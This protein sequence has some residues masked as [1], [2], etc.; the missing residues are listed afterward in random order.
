MVCHRS[1]CICVHRASSED[2]NSKMQKEVQNGL[3]C[4]VFF[5]SLHVR[6]GHLITYIHKDRKNS[7]I[8]PF[9]ASGRDLHE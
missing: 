4:M 1:L 5:R 6:A 2:V 7:S 8:L 3:I 9:L